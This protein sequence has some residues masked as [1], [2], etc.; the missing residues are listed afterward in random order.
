MDDGSQEHYYTRCYQGHCN[1]RTVK[2]VNFIGP[3]SE[4]VVSGSDDGRI[5][6]WDKATSQVVNIM[7]GDTH[8]VN[9]V[10]AHPFDT[11]LATSGIDDNVKLW[12]PIDKQPTLLENFET[13][14]ADN[15]AALS[16]RP[17]HNVIPLSVLQAL[18]NRSLHP[19][20]EEEAEDHSEGVSCEYQ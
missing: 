16:D 6:I 17:R 13:I 14:I 7:K 11:V 4:Y 1:I 15:K 8:V 19:G 3:N 10:A 9:C 20:E 18:I 5:F 2:E 12:E